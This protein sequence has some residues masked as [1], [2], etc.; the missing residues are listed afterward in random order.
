MTPVFFGSVSEEG[1]LILGNPEG[2]SK[3]LLTLAGKEIQVIVRKFEKTR[4]NEANRYYWGVVVD[5]IA[6][7]MGILKDEAHDFGK[8]LFLKEGL[9]VNGKRYELI[10]STANL[11]TSEFWSYIDKLKM[12]ASSELQIYIPEPNEVE[13]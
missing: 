9:E 10:R 8:S 13:Y 5:M 7:A 6:E 11:P 4:S 1:K 2:F 12:W 3:Y